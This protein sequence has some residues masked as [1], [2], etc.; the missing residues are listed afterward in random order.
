LIWT[1]W[2]NVLVRS[3]HRRRQLSNDESDGYITRKGSSTATSDG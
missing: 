2:W 1:D 3:Q